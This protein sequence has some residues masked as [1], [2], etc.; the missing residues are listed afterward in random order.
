MSI[1]GR[2]KNPNTF[3]YY[4][5]SYTDRIQAINQVGMNNPGNRS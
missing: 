3:H 2:E 5:E 1:T 4:G